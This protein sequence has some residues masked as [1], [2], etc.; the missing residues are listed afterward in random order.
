MAPAFPVILTWFI[1]KEMDKAEVRWM[2]VFFFQKETADTGTAQ[3]TIHLGCNS[4]WMPTW[5]RLSLPQAGLQRFWQGKSGQEEVENFSFTFHW[6]TWTRNQCFR[7][8]LSCF[9]R[10]D[11][12]ILQSALKGA[13]AGTV[14]SCREG[15]HV[16]FPVRKTPSLSVCLQNTDSLRIWLSVQAGHGDYFSRENSCNC[17]C[18]THG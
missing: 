16:A 12:P 3:K 4:G 18:N 5:N 17:C 15:S 7:P 1:P 13:A 10:Q 11:S 9:P 2:E 6:E 14:Q 8:T